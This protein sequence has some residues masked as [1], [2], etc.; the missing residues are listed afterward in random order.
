MRH[1]FTDTSHRQKRKNFEEEA[2]NYNNINNADEK[3]RVGQGETE[4]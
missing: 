4:L 2:V 1:R 3:V